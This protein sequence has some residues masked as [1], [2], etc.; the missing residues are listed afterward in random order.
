MSDRAKVPPVNDACAVSA[1]I[2]ICSV[3]SCSVREPVKREMDK[4]DLH[5]QC[6]P[7]HFNT[8]GHCLSDLFSFI[9]SHAAQFVENAAGF[10]FFWISKVNLLCRL[11][12]ST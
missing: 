8:C 11:A 9:F 3:L 2:T 12:V 4:R 5:C 10:L 6:L 1:C 7:V